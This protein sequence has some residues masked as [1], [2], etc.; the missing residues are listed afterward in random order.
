MSI[1]RQILD[2]LAAIRARRSLSILFISHDL[3]AVRMICDRVVVMKDGVV[4]ETGPIDRI[5]SRPAHAYTRELIQAAAL[6]PDP[7]TAVDASSQ[8]RQPA[9]TRA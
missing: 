1:Q 8:D 5:L 9:I 7:M 4:V 6:A 2:L 3:R